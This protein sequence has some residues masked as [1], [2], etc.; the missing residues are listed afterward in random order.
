MTE[1]GRT[2]DE[3][4]RGR[5]GAGLESRGVRALIV[6]LILVNAVDLGLGTVPELQARVGPLL[7]WFDEACILVFGVEIAARIVAY[8]GAFF[9]S[10]WN[11]FDLVVVGAALMPSEHFVSILMTLRLL[12][13][14][15][16]ISTLPSL[17]QVVQGLIDALPGMASV[18]V[19]LVLLLYVAAVLG[20]DLFGTRF[21]DW[22]GTVGHAMYT[23]FQVLTLDGWSDAIARP[24]MAVYPFAWVYFVAFILLVTM[25]VLNLFVGVLV[26]SLSGPDRSGALVREI[27]A[28]R[29]EVAELKDMMGGQG[30]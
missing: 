17:R 23:M 4:W 2:R 7:F 26:N 5:L 11:V 18:T 27:A 14:L 15:R 6:A 29:K 16:L 9:R 30:R 8:R 12:W 13:V 25:A 19:L 24:V 28:L 20:C 1:P 22:F 10:G 3:G 21:P